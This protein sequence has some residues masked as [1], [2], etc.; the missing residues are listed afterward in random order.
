MIKYSNSPQVF[1][2]SGSRRCLIRLGLPSCSSSAC[3]N[4]NKNRAS[5]PCRVMSKMAEVVLMFLPAV[6]AMWLDRKT[7]CTLV[8]VLNPW[9]RGWHHQMQQRHDPA[10]RNDG[11]L[12]K[13]AGTRWRGHFYKPTLEPTQVRPL[14]PKHLTAKTYISVVRFGI[15]KFF[16]QD[17]S[18]LY[19]RHAAC[20]LLCRDR[21][22]WV[23]CPQKSC[24]C[25][26]QLYG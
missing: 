10:L 18:R 4:F 17:L 24:I 2:T 22:G 20:R 16:P 12:K 15:W 19:T 14:F 11:N 23:E 26:Q 7:G 6:A 8:E 1:R 3:N 9:S 25:D 13:R 21:L 5:R